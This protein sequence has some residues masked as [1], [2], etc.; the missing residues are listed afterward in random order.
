[1]GI[2]GFHEGCFCSFLKIVSVAAVG[3]Q[4]YGT[5]NYFS[6]VGVDDG[7]AVVWCLFNFGDSRILLPLTKRLPFRIQPCEVRIRPFLKSR[8]SSINLNVNALPLIP[9]ENVSGVHF[10]VYIVQTVVIAVGDDGV[11]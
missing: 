7:C 1:M 3:M 8:I 4:F 5:G 9:T 6:A 10:V 11:A 2:D